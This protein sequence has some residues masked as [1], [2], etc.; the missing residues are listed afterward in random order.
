MYL[1]KCPPPN[2][3][4]RIPFPSIHTGAQP[5]DLIDHTRIQLTG[6]G[7]G[8]QMGQSGWSNPES[9]DGSWCRSSPPHPPSCCRVELEP[10]GHMH[11]RWRNQ[12]SAVATGPGRVRVQSWGLLVQPSRTGSSS[13]SGGD[14]ASPLHG[15]VIAGGIVLVRPRPWE[16]SFAG[17]RRTGRRSP[18]EI[19]ACR[20]RK[21]TETKTHDFVLCSWASGC[22]S[23]SCI[24][25]KAP[26]HPTK[27]FA[28]RKKGETG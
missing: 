10:M 28:R 8:I 6:P 1:H 27:R 9:A 18:A 23:A 12:P 14:W 11:L 26:S 25:G 2:Y 16:S 5:L 21:R 15:A 24:S 13:V 17:G 3:S 22:S 19:R 20:P 7:N 4:F